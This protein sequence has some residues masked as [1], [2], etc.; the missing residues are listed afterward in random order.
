MLERRDSAGDHRVVCDRES[1]PAAA[2]SPVIRHILIALAALLFLVVGAPAVGD[3]AAPGSV[4][5]VGYGCP[6]LGHRAPVKR[7]T[8]PPSPAPSPPQIYYNNDWRLGPAELPSPP[9]GGLFSGYD[10]TGGMSAQNFVSCYW[11]TGKDDQGRTVQGWQYPDADGFLGNTT[12]IELKEGQMVDRFGGETGSFAAPVG[13]PYGQRSLP[14]S[15][16]NAIGTGPRYD[17][18]V[19]RVAKGKTVKVVSG[20]ARA[21]F[22]QPGMGLQY[23]FNASMQDL[24]RNQVLERVS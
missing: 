13:T 9:L 6:G 21:W 15:N 10:R 14:P 3:A 16:L 17:Y 8:N 19:Y 5:Q 2:T 22:G 4:G 1:P 20:R 23:S 11:R 7:A 12:P 24:V 18:Y